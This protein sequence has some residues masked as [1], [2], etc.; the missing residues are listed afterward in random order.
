MF[1]KAKNIDTAFRH[2]RAFTVI[3]IIC[4]I[5][6]CCFAVYKSYQLVD[7]TQ[8]KVYILASGKVLDAYAFE[9]NENI[10]VEARDHVATFHRYFFSLD[11]DDKVI[12]SNLVKA[13]Y[14]ADASAKAQYENLKESGFYTSII[15]G[16]IS[17]QISVDTVEIKT[18][19]YPY[20]FHCVASQRIIRSTSIVTRKL[21]TEGY[22]RSVSRSD[23]NPHGFLIERWT[24][25]EN[26]DVNVQNR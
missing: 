1:T 22:L 11:P 9:R 17:Q 24:T 19:D 10:P 3:I 6:F 7:K 14:L 26:K 15:S 25:L 12:Q 5:G 2:V 18:D 20:Y 8:D 4:S 13:L 23:N 21:V 16:N